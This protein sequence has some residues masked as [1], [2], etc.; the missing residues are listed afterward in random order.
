MSGAKCFFLRGKE[1]KQQLNFR[2]FLIAA[3][4]GSLIWCIT[5]PCIGW[6]LGP[7]WRI[8]LYF[9]RTYTLPTIIGIVL[10]VIVYAVVTYL[11]KRAINAKYHTISG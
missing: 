11:V 1:R 4:A 8:A 6:L 9:M 5:L 10:L 2:K 7:R 3:V